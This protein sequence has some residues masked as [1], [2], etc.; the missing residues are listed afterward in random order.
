MGKKGYCVDP[1]KLHKKRVFKFI[2]SVSSD[3][4]GLKGLRKGEKICNNCRSRLAKFKDQPEEL[5][6]SCS[7]TTTSITTEDEMSSHQVP[8]TFKGAIAAY[9]API[10]S[11]DDE[12]AQVT[13]EE[14]LPMLQE[15]PV[16]LRKYRVRPPM[17]THTPMGTHFWVKKLQGENYRADF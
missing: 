14:V 2:G 13:L 12:S 4:A 8:R 7:S 15:T 1:F 10:M 6:A 3:L 9:T 17:G 5:Q 11:T 16:K